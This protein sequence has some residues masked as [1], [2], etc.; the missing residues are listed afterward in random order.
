MTATLD[1]SWSI[2]DDDTN[3][4]RTARSR[5]SSLTDPDPQSHLPTMMPNGIR[6]GTPLAREAAKSFWSMDMFKTSLNRMAFY[7]DCENHSEG[8][9]VSADSGYHSRAPSER[10]T[11][12]IP[13]L[14][15]LTT[16]APSSP[17]IPA[18]SERRQTAI[19]TSTD[20]EHEI[21]V[22][23][24][25]TPLLQPLLCPVSESPLLI[26][27]REKEAVR[28]TSSPRGTNSTASLSSS[29]KTISPSLSQTLLPR[30][31]HRRSFSAE[32][33]Y[34]IAHP[35]MQL[36]SRKGLRE[37]RSDSSV[38]HLARTHQYS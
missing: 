30:R 21:V 38:F 27:R 12:T 11:P 26:A 33:R 20:T 25:V 32:H 28:H 35:P 23:S 18:R 19:P 4:K 36:M 7:A 1:A 13:Q 24:H 14:P 15:I 10:A 29:S 37:A 34:R 17:A 22:G 9:L 2:G 6:L 16:S 8:S 31:Q 3:Y 5:S